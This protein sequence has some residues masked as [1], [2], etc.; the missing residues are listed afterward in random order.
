MQRRGDANFTTNW[1]SGDEGDQ[2]DF[3]FFI[4][5]NG[6]RLVA[7]LAGSKQVGRFG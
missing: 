7:F 4:S 3:T 5:L 2:I 1:R 6:T